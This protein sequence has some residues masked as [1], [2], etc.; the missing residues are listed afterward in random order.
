MTLVDDR[1]P[2]VGPVEA[3]H[4]EGRV[5]QAEATAHVVA[6]LGV[7]RGGAG[8]D[9]HAGEEAAQASE[10]DVLGTEVV[11]PLRDAVRLVDGEEGDGDAGIGLSAQIELGLLAV[12]RRVA[13]AALPRHRASA[14]RA[15]SRRASAQTIEEALGHE[16]FGR[17]VEQVELAGVQERQ[18]PARLGRLERRVVERGPHAAGAQGVDLVLHQRD[19]RR[20]HDA[21]AGSQQRRDLVAERLAAAGR[22]EDE[23]A[24]P[25]GDVLDDLLLLRPERG[26]A[27]DVAQHASQRVW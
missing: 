14:H 11:A 17:H 18:H 19:E 27:E 21:D 16:P 1:V 23:A 13:G 25:G 7:G 9:R 20:D 3:G 12:A 5:G 4:V 22:H 8:H 26:E 6:R 2:D 10:V 24:S 15:A